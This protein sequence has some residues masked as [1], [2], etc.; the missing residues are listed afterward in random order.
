MSYHIILK[1]IFIRITQSCIF[2]HEICMILPRIMMRVCLRY[3][4]RIVQILCDKRRLCDILIKMSFTKISNT[5]GLGY[6]CIKE[7]YP[8][9]SCHFILCIQVNVITRNWDYIYKWTNIVPVIPTSAPKT[10]L[11]AA[12]TSTF[13]PVFMKE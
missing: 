7:A 9:T 4:G 8:C 6:L 5:L 1:L 12:N 3:G 10:P 2:S 13:P 11:I